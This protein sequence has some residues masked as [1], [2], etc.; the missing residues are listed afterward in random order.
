VQGDAGTM[1][2]SENAGSDPQILFEGA[3][4]AVIAR[5]IETGMRIDLAVSDY[6][7]HFS[8]HDINTY[9]GPDMIICVSDCLRLIRHAA[10]AKGNTVLILDDAIRVWRGTDDANR[11]PADDRTTLIQAC[12][13]NIRRALESTA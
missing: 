1:S 4:L 12:I 9:I 6:L 3:V 7:A 11:R 10:G 8:T 13:G 5:V 2:G